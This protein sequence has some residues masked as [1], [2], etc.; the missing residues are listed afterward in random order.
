MEKLL[1]AALE[2]AKQ[3]EVYLI[4]EESIPVQFGNNEVKRI[5]SKKTLGVTLR[6]ID[7]EGRMGFVSGTQLDREALIQQAM[8]SAKYG[9]KTEIVFPNEQQTEEVQCYDPKVANLTTEEMVEQGQQI[10]TIIQELDPSITCDLMISKEIQRVK[11]INS[12]GLDV[13]F[14]KTKYAI[15]LS[16]RG[17]DGFRLY[18]DFDIYSKYFTFDRD[19]LEK[20]V[21]YHQLSLKRF[22]V[23][24][25]KMDILFN[26]KAIWPFLY[27]LFAGVNGLSVNED[28]TPLKGRLGREIFSPLIS[29]IDD[30][31]YPGGLA[32][33]P[34]D[35]EGSVAHKTPIV[36]KGVLKNY[37]FNLDSAFEYGTKSTGNGFKKTLFAKGIDQRP[38]TYGSNFNLLPGESTF[39][40]MVQSMKRGLI[41]DQIMGGHTG[42]ILAGEFGL[43]IVT[44]FLVE[45]GEIK[46][47]VIDAMVSGNIYD[48]FKKVAMVGNEMQ[49]TQ[50]VFYG[51]GYTP[52]ILVSDLMVAGVDE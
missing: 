18:S 19:R 5:N 26:P 33:T 31:T 48:L 13:S 43:T 21:K 27:R 30:P 20:F 44:G 50:A 37:L 51:F 32:S 28:I 40:E 47:K 9:D 42:N 49:S 36:E 3:A 45:D 22:K 4:E 14:A 15:H 10:L 11:I 6:V 34:Y 52:A 38:A 41:V 29:F 12:S 25:G 16:S 1:H 17:D 39:E 2:Q 23:A 8:T 46:G 24:T 7:Q 35:D